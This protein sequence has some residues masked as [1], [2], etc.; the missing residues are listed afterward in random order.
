MPTIHIRIRRMKSS[1]PLRG[2]LSLTVV[3]PISPESTDS[4]EAGQQEEEE[5]QDSSDITELIGTLT[6]Q[7][8]EMQRDSS[9]L[10]KQVKN[11][12]VRAK[13]ELTDLTQ[14]PLN[15]IPSV[16]VWCL[17]HGLSETPTLFE[18][19]DACFKVALSMNAE[20]R[21]LQ[22]APEDAACLWNSRETF[23]IY[24]LFARIP[25]LIDAPSS[26]Q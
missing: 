1:P 2:Q 10:R 19:L 14:I 7:L 9:V 13:E 8:T 15:L 18:F 12:Y 4:D 21:T 20:T 22:F 23:T 24:E 25:N 11:L 26:S 3:P 17:A 6:E 5:D 16:K